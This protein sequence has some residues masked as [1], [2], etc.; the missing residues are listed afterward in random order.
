M[1]KPLLIIPI[2]IKAREFPAR[3][4]FA[5]KALEQG[6]PVLI[7]VSKRLH[8]HLYQF[9]RGI[10]V[11]NDASP[12]SQAFLTKAR[13][14]GFRIVGW[15]EESIVTLSDDIFA[16]IRV[17][18]QSLSLMDA[19]FT[20]GKSDRDAIA[21]IHTEQSARVFEAGNPRL[22]ILHHKWW[23]PR[24]KARDQAFTILVNSR[25]SIVNP[26]HITKEK[27]VANVFS[28]MEI[29]RESQIGQQVSGWLSHA[30]DLYTLF[31][32]MTE[33]MA[34]RFPD[35]KIIIRPHPSENHTVWKD[36]AKKYDNCTYDFSGS[37]SGWFNRADLLVHSSCTTAIE[38]SLLGLPCLSYLPKGQTP[39][40]AP[41]P[42]AVSLCVE[43]TADLFR[44]IEKY[45][46]NP[47]LERETIANQK[48]KTLSQHIAGLQN[49][50]SSE[51]ILQKISEIECYHDT[52]LRH[53]KNRYLDCARTMKNLLK[54]KFSFNLHKDE[55]LKEARRDYQTQK[56]SG[57]NRQEISQTLDFFG[58]DS[59]QIKP[60]GA[61]W[62]WLKP[63]GHP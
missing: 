5:G 21:R 38:A 23:P 43:E 60:Y 26:F 6:Y 32:E 11:E 44:E 34:Q 56:F 61:Q 3:T 31:F 15:D 10:I 57:L 45:R 50:S 20:R 35:C 46:K 13:S 39:Y 29:T 30:S 17:S 33:K 25:F 22:E 9:P 55:K 16:Q 12:R 47:Q 4:F 51:I 18:S 58:F 24:Q 14:M 53:L 7:G 36:L 52:E 54:N 19:Y 1:T 48:R 37:A 8:R 28:K 62:W 59:P 49:P 40:D 42:N 27:A 63:R 2:E 41:L